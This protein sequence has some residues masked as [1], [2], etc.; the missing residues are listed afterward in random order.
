MYKCSFSYGAWSEAYIFDE[1]SVT[2]I[3]PNIVPSSGASD[4]EI[5]RESLTHPIG[6]GMIT[7][8]VKGCQNVLILVDDYTRLTPCSIILPEVIKELLLGGIEKSQ[9]KIMV[10]SGTHRAM[11]R[12]EKELKYGKEIVDSI[13]ILD[14]LWSEIDNLVYDGQ[15]TH[16]TEIY[17]NSIM[18]KSDFVIGIG[19]IVPHRVAGFSGGAKIVQPGICGDITTGQTHWLSAKYF[20][21]RDIMGVYKNPVRKEINEVGSKSGLSFIINTVQNTNGKIQSCYSGNP[22]E[23]HKTGCEAALEV[24]GKE[25]HELFDIVIVDA[26]PANMNMWQSSKGI[27]SADLALKEDGVLILVTPCPEGIAN[28]HPEIEQYGYSQPGKI[29]EMVDRGEIV[30]L[31]IAAHI[32]HVGKV[33]V[34]KRKAFLVSPGI[35]KEKSEHIGFKWA[36]NLQDAYERALKEKDSS[37]KVAVMYH[38]GEVLPLLKN[39]IL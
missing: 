16:G 7:D 10:A 3:T 2:V 28:E 20:V 25:I 29:E 5:I 12:G 1:N 32:L 11:T 33:I 39:E 8:E 27:Y 34:G 19:H 23:A 15:T 31:T 26:Y 4:I 13:Q 37:V 24:F 21:G 17:I 14:H 6:S 9:I 18:G 38:G 36:E 35:N 22:V 30:N